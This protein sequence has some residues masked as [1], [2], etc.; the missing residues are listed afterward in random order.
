MDTMGAVAARAFILVIAMA[1]LGCG[2]GVGPDAGEGPFVDAPP[3]ACV[4]RLADFCDGFCP[5]LSQSVAEV[6][7]RGGE[8]FCVTAEEG[9][10]GPFRYTSFSSGFSGFTAWFGDDGAL[11]AGMRFADFPAF[12][13]D[14]MHTQ[15]FGPTPACVRQRTVQ[16]CQE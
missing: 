5:T 6:Q 3:G 7:R 8:G 9:M 16:Y 13:G 10:C 15:L 14:R 4:G 1:Q 2:D 11:V 12:C